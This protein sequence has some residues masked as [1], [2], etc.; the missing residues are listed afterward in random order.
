MEI[1]NCLVDKIIFE[2]DN[3]VVA[4]MISNNTHF[5]ATLSQKCKTG[6]RLNLNG[7]WVIHK[8]YGRQFKTVFAEIPHDLTEEEIEIFL[9][10]IKG[11]GPVR[12]KKIVKTFGIDALNVIEMSPIRLKEAGIPESVIEEVYREIKEN[13]EFNKIKLALLPLGF[14]LNIIKKIYKKYKDKTLQQLQTNPYKVAEDITGIGFIKADEIASKM[15][16]PYDSPFRIQAGIKYVLYKEETNGHIY[17]PYFDLIDEVTKFLAK[18]KPIDT[19]KITENL[20]LLEKIGDITV[21]NNCVYAKSNFNEENYIAKKLKLMMEAKPEKEIKDTDKI[22]KEIEQKNKIKYADKQFEAIK[23]SLI[24]NVSVIT[25]GPGTGK[26]T[27]VNAILNILSNNEWTV[28]LAAPTGKAAKRLSEVTGHEAKTIHRL[29]ECK[30]NE[31]TGNVYYA[32]NE[33]NPL[34]ADAVIIDETSMIDN[35][36]MYHLLKGLKNTTKLI[37][38]GDA[39]QLPSVGAGNILKDIIESGVIPVTKLDV[40]YRQKNMSSIVINSKYINEGKMPYFNIKDFLFDELISP[41]QVIETYLQELKQGKTINDVQILTP[42][43]KTAVGTIELNKL[44]QQAVNPPHESKKEI[45]YGETIYRVGDKVMQTA[46]NYEKWIFNGD[47]GIII[48][49]YTDEENLR[50]LVIDFDGNIIDIAEEE[51]KDIMLAYAITVHKSQGSEYDT[52]IIP[53]TTSHFI[54]LKRN[55]LYT[56]VTRAKNK[57]IMLGSKKAVWIAVNTIDSSIRYTGLKE[58]LKQLF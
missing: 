8:K 22:I 13:E 46:N 5:I 18:K 24:S 26:T 40:I 29:L 57:V 42:M 2:T 31:T 36:L 28:E 15:G 44:I 20:N 7:E 25:G 11:I 51:I 30:I 21:E 52:V 4:S 33:S 45:K 3:F 6:Q 32:V 9:R 54:M 23:K 19:E 48:D 17:Y 56:A 16:I 43:K 34:D 53:I 55:L 39:D 50:H 37:L 1:K 10:N 12:A 38:V 47:T 35:N 58:K 27:V 49:A 41:E 14:S